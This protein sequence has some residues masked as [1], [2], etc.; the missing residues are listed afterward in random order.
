MK[1]HIFLLA[2][3][4]LSVLAFSQVQNIR[5]KNV[6]ADS[7]VKTNKIAANNLAG[8]PDYEIIVFPDIQNMI[9]YNQAYSRSM[10]KWVADNRISR[11]IKALLQVGDITDWNTNAEWDTLNSQ[12]SLVSGSPLPYLFV[13]GNHDYGNGFNPATRDA[14][15]YN[16]NLGV[17]H[18]TGKP[19]YKGHYGTTNENYFIT[20]E[21]GAKKYLAMG[22]EFIPRDAVVT[23]ASNILDSVYAADPYREVMIVTHAYITVPG[24]RSTDT[25][26]YSGVTYG[27]SA[28]NSGQELWDK[29]IKKKP[30]I[31]WVF[32]GH[33][34]IPNAWA[35]M[36]LT[37][38]IVSV[39]EN[40]NLINQIFVNYQDDVNWGDG[41]FMRLQFSPSRNKVDVKFYS[42]FSNQFDP[43]I[44]SYTLEDPNP[45]VISS[46]GV[47]TDASIGR[48][49]RVG[50]EIKSESWRKGSVLYAGDDTKAA[51]DTFLTYIPKRYWFS[52][53]SLTVGKI[54]FRKH[55]QQ[56][57]PV[58]YVRDSLG[59]ILCE[60]R[61]Q[62][63]GEASLYLGTGAG[64]NYTA[65]QAAFTIPNNV[66]IGFWNQRSNLSAFNTVSLG[67]RTFYRLETGAFLVAVGNAAAYSALT[68]TDATIYGNNAAGGA[69]AINR[70]HIAGSDAALS[71]IGTI[72]GAVIIGAGASRQTSGGVDSSVVIGTQAARNVTVTKRSVIIGFQTGYLA[73]TLL[74]KLMIDNSLTNSPL[75]HGDFATDS[76]SINGNFNVRDRFS[77]TVGA[78]KSAGTATLVAGTVTV[79]TT[80]VRS[81]SLIFLTVNTPGGTR[82]WLSAPSSSIVNGTSFVINSS[83]NTETSTVNWWFIN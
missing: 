30:N 42:S 37:D 9:R 44:S 67:A 75:I 55:T 57:R 10:F 29:L 38:R 17:A 77:V 45:T 82:G 12:L 52:G 69:S 64:E 33:F 21:A 16:A 27:M 20:F 53:D 81:T 80:M 19:F 63:N 14:T 31:K 8:G 73:G 66:G 5:G 70:S 83:S 32:S 6:S 3:L 59:N 2:F 24:E 48:D 43:R 74:D 15:K 18:F 65:Y 71:T 49:L 56:N 61:S 13:P 50:G 1:K 68:G 36:G 62:I 35:Q 79:N 60:M 22:L 23:W 26:V 76:L 72:E 51:T 46:L 28:D 47:Q 39:G 7:S 40:G 41:Y 11:N 34:L 25:S 4:L 78:N 58:F 54:L